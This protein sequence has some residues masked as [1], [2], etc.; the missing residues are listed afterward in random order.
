MSKKNMQEPEAET[1]DSILKNLQSSERDNT[2][3][4]VR[5]ELKPARAQWLLELVG[6][7][8]KTLTFDTDEFQEAYSLYQSLRGQ[9][10]QISDG[11][12]T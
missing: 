7:E 2:R 9:M 5:I 11:E 8:L 12:A 4:R 1:P 10:K 3:T 6:K